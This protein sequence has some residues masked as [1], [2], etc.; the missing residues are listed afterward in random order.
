[1]PSQ[2]SCKTSLKSFLE[3][4]YSN[5]YLKFEDVMRYFH[6]S[7]SHGYALF[8]KHLGAPFGI[9]LRNVRLTKAKDAMKN[10]PYSITEIAYLCGFTSLSTFSKVFKEKYGDNPTTFRKKAFGII[11]LGKPAV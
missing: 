2:D 8:K 11:P 10:T 9:C 1:M 7:K 5:P 4:H 6:F 3:A